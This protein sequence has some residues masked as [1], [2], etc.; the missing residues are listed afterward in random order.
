L[1]AYSQRL[2]WNLS[3]NSLSLLIQEKL[4]AGVPLLD[5]TISNPTQTF[6]D[7]PHDEIRRAYANI[8]DFTYRPDPLG[9]K[10]AR[11]AIARVYAEQGIPVSPDQLVLTAS[12]SEAYALLFKLF[13]DPEDEVLVPAPSYPLFDFL[14]RLESIRVV[15][16][17][18]QYDGIWCIDLAS[19]RERISSRTR[20]VVIVNPNNPTGSFFKESERNELFELARQH[21]LP[22]ISDEVFRDYSL[23]STGSQVTTLINSDMVLSFSLNGLSKTAG[24]PQMKLGWIAINGPVAE[25]KLARARLEI[26]LDTYL[27]VSTPVQSAL[28]ELLSIGSG[29]RCRIAERTKRNVAALEA[30]LNHSPAH[31]LHTEGGWSAIVRLPHTAT[32][33]VW[34]ARLLE[35]RAVIVQPGY[36]FDMDSEPYVVISLITPPEIFDEGIRRL[37]ALVAC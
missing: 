20:A 24:M 9:L 19:L 32:E 1:R 14:A 28:P 13:C 18:L 29:I 37:R 12:S 25:R 22:I 33:E 35:E 30:L 7:Y 17:R 23:G 10:Q 31:G 11:C 4:N 15:P 16:Y 2:S 21:D 36:F 8:T 26:L 34:V 6:A 27:S 3:P 5:L